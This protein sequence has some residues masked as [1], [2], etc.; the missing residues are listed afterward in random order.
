MRRF[1]VAIAALVVTVAA[2]TTPPRE[3]LASWVEAEYATGQLAAVTLPN[4]PGPI[5]CANRSV[6]LLPSYVTVSWAAPPALPAGAEYEVRLTKG[7]FT[8]SL[9]TSNLSQDISVSALDLLGFLLG[10]SGTLTVDVRTVF[11]NGTSV[12]W[13]SPAFTSRTIVY[14]APVVGLLLGG[15]TCA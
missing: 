10:N 5:A 2:F 4:V 6:V 11:R 15:F 3:T 9:F 7:T 8:A 13:T 1:I 12:T 14:T